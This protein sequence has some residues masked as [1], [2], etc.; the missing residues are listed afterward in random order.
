MSLSIYSITGVEVERLFNGKQ[1]FG[2]HI[3]VWN[4]GGFPSGVYFYRL[5]VGTN[6]QSQRMLLVK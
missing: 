5:Q 1:G 3:V 6:I 4:A 2:E